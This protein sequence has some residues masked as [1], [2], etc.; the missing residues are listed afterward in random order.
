VEKY[1]R[2]GQ[3]TDD[4]MARAYCMLD[5]ENCTHTHTHKHTLRICNTYCFSA[6][7][8]VARTRLNVTLY[9]MTCLVVTVINPLYPVAGSSCFLL[10]ALRF[11]FRAGKKLSLSHVSKEL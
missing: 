10:W 2:A 5:N 3:A 4:N 7:A 6:E 1:C 9:Y 8:M 11:E